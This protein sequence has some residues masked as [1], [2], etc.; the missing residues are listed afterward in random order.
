[1][2]IIRNIIII[3]AVIV[4]AFLIWM[5]T[6]PAAF[7]VEKTIEIDA[8]P[9]DVYAYVS[10][11]KT[12]PEWSAWSEMDP[13]AT[14]TYGEISAGEGASYTW[15]GEIMKTGS[16]SITS[17][18]GVSNIK[19][20][21]V[22]DGMGESDGYWKIEPAENNMTKVTW[23]FDSEL[24]LFLRFMAKGIQEQTGGDFEKGLA[25]IKANMESMERAPDVEIEVV[26]VEGQNYYGIKSELAWEDLNSEFFDSNYDEIKAFLG[27]DSKNITMAPFALYHK[28]DEENQRAEVEPGIAAA[29]TKKGNDRIKQGTTH[30]GTALK[31]VHMGGFNTMAEHEALYAFSAENG[32]EMIGSPWEV[33]ITDPQTEPDTSKWIVEVYYP[34]IIGDS[35]EPLE[36]SEP[37]EKAMNE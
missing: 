25:N 5:S 32:F 1:M 27:D 24:P 30:S 26:T 33:Y 8:D 10:D 21:I 35:D 36:P 6:L 37:A 12:W 28:W 29:S 23:G 17:A 9:A 13:E 7:N 3:L 14:Y 22:F 4:G 18:D 31:A 15:S 19:T 16:Q 2:K 20:H 11:F 34:V